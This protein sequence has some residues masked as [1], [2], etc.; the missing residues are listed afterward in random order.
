PKGAFK[1]LEAAFLDN[2]SEPDLW[3]R[4][5]G[6]AEAAGMH[7]NLAEAYSTAVDAGELDESSVAELSA[8]AAEIYDVILGE[9]AKAEPFH[10][11]RLALDPLD[12]RAFEALKEL[13]TTS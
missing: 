2:P 8:R 3:D 5:A 4:L 13:Y 11:K 12:E 1:A 9:P 7:E 6:V 10:K